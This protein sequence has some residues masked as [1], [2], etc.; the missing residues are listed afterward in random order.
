[1]TDAARR[2]SPHRSTPARH[3]FLT[4]LLIMT[5]VKSTFG[6]TPPAPP[7]SVIAS[8]HPNDRGDQIRVRWTLSTDDNATA[9]DPLVTG[10]Q[11]LRREDGT[12][13]FRTV[14]E[15]PAQT[16]EYIDNTVERGRPY[17]YAVAAVSEF[18]VSENAEAADAVIPSMDWFRQDRGWL[19]IMIVVICGSVVAFIVVA[20][21][22]RSLYVRRIPGLEAVDE[23][24]GR[25]TEMGR[26]CLFVPGIQDINDIQTVAGLTILSRVSTLT[27]EY[28]AGL[29]VPTSRSLVMTTA[30]E[31]V[32]ASY[33]AAGRPDEYR[34][35]DI[36]YLTDEQF[37]YV[38]SVT[39]TMMEERPAACF[40]MG[41][42]FAESLI[43]AETGNA[44]GAIQVAGTA[45]PS[46][47]PFFVAACDYTLI[48]EEFFAASAYLSGEPVQLGS[49]RGQDIGKLI[50]ATLII[51]ACGLATWQAVFQ[52]ELPVLA[53]LT[54]N[55]LGDNGFFRQ[56]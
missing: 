40:Y 22:G 35:D 13:Q 41:S 3:S 31:T 12:A 7:T 11:L 30:R 24:V 26:S 39:A 33:L 14:A 2:Y 46:Q 9:E 8:D 50:A 28:G 6:Q 47:L 56:Q 25:A 29:T 18:G 49:L 45:Q 37:G 32:A 53:Y 16:T 43:L 19:A 1:M 5:V 48:G 44:V 20:R 38:A 54:E 34:E 4:L 17:R 51:V 15:I 55:V 42:F 21:S 52:T 10:Y 27:A 23:A 36:Y